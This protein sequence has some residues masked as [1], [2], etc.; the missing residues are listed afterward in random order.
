[1]W[2]MMLAAVYLMR[3]SHVVHDVSSS[4][5]YEAVSCGT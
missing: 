4:I 3:Q 5:P 1:M 2:Y